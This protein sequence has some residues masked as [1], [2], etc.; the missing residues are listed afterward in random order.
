MIYLQP[1]GD[2]P[3]YLQELRLQN[4]DRLD[5]EELRHQAERTGSPKLRRAAEFV[6]EL[7]CTETQEYQTL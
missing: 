7:R 1:G 4:L 5:A 6:V 3:A 2:S